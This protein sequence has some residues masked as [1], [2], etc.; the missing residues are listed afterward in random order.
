M[1]KARELGA[2]I[3]LEHGSS[4]IKYQTSILKEEYEKFGLKVK[5]AHPKIIEKV[6]KEFEE[7]DY[8]SIPSLFVKRTFLEKGIPENKLIHIPFGVDL[9]QFQ[10]IPKEDDVFRVIFTGGM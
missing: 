2:V 3:V 1:Q 6:L 7:A 5:T 8:I 10:Q 4:H 9:S